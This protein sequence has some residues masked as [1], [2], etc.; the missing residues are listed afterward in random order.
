MTY[1]AA[2]DWLYGS[3]L[4]GIK[5]GLEPIRRLCDGLGLDLTGGGGPVFIHVAGTN[6]KGSAFDIESLPIVSLRS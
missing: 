4:H 1:P 6:G 2:L 5:L 3:Q